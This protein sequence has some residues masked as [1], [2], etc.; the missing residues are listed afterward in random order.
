MS[1]PKAIRSWQTKQLES[2][3]PMQ[4]D[5]FARH[6]GFARDL[7]LLAG[8]TKQESTHL[9]TPCQWYQTK[10]QT[11]YSWI[12]VGSRPLIIP[13]PV[14]SVDYMAKENRIINPNLAWHVAPETNWVPVMYEE[15]RWTTIQASKKDRPKWSSSA[16]E[17]NLPIIVLC[18]CKIVP[19]QTLRTS[20]NP[21][22]GPTKFVLHSEIWLRHGAL[23]SQVCGP[24]QK[25]H[26]WNA[27]LP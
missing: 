18:Y 10:H 12:T 2:N 5:T 19:S 21:L 1:L 22:A 16:A 9:Q 15:L 17:A 4:L 6:T 20:W 23:D 7:H 14:V 27:A 26:S 8:K 25:T 3:T 24:S 13:Y 11:I